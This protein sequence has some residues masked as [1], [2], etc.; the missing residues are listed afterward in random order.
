MWSSFSLLI[1]SISVAAT[2][3][4]GLKV[5]SCWAN[6]SDCFVISPLSLSSEQLFV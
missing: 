2:L 6:F 3:N 5:L 4:E 1:S